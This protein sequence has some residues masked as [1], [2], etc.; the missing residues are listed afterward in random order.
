MALTV[1]TYLVLGFRSVTST[2]LLL[3]ST[4]ICRTEDK[5]HRYTSMTVE[6]PHVSNRLGARGFTSDAK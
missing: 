2:V 6:D 3:P 1:K 4:T 5:G